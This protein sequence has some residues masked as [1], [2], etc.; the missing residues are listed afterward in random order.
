MRLKL[1]RIKEDY[2]KNSKSKKCVLE[3]VDLGHKDNE[4]R[5]LEKDLVTIKRYA[6]DLIQLM[7]QLDSMEADIDFPHWWQSKIVK[8]KDY[9]ISA[10]HYIRAELDVDDDILQNK[11]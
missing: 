4:P 10:K 7:G 3:D 2:N 1:K 9:M 11:K 8:A 5:M 6:S